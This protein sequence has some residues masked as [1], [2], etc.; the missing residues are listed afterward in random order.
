MENKTES[1]NFT[2]LHYDAAV[3]LQKQSLISILNPIKKPA[4][5]TSSSSNRK[6]AKI[7]TNLESRLD[8]ENK[9]DD[10]T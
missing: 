8:K 10:R 9:V 3:M 5:S 2:L 7:R 4:V 6:K 1:E